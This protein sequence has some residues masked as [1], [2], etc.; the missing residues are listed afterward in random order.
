M[1]A[2]SGTLTGKA[3]LLLCGAV[4]LALVANFF[5]ITEAYGK[6]R[7]NSNSSSHIEAPVP[8]RPEPIEGNE[9]R[10]YPYFSSP[11]QRRTESPGTTYN[12][13]AILTDEATDVSVIGTFSEGA[14]MSVTQGEDALHKGETCSACEDI[15]AMRS[16]SQYFEAFNIDIDSYAGVFPKGSFNVGEQFDYKHVK[17]LHC[18]NGAIEE[19]YSIVE[20]GRAE[21]RFEPSKPFAIVIP[22]DAP[23]P[24][25]EEAEPPQEEPEETTPTDWTPIL[26]VGLVAFLI[27]LSR[28]VYNHNRK[29]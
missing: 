25:Q 23:E 28:K 17:V 4:L 24:P 1:K 15:R 19:T 20:K 2:T 9:E 7:Y 3:L 12:S 14:K 6:I 5:S 8:Q 10:E 26:V 11:Y 29:A 18:I 27:I 16:D 13:D 22:D 21:T